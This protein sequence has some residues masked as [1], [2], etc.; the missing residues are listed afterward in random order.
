MKRDNERRSGDE[1]RVAPVF[2]AWRETWTA[3]T[4][5]PNRR[6]HHFRDVHGLAHVDRALRRVTEDEVRR[7]VS[8]ETGA[9][10]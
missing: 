8:H 3:R 10:S 1:R 7:V 2:Q 6:R 5:I 4:I 9:R